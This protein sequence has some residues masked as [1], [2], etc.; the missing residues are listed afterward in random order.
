MEWVEKERNRKKKKEKIEI[1]NDK[2]DKLC[3]EKDKKNM[4]RK[5]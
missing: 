5:I 4:R 3:D 2:S 1:K